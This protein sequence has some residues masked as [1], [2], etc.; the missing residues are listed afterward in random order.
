[1]STTPATDTP[2][3]NTPTTPEID[4]SENDPASST[5]ISD[6]DTKSGKCTSNDINC[7]LTEDYWENMDAEAEGPLVKL[8]ESLP[9]DLRILFQ[10]EKETVLSQ[11]EASGLEWTKVT[12]S[13]FDTTAYVELDN[14]YLE[15]EMIIAAT[16]NPDKITFTEEKYKEIPN[17]SEDEITDKTFVI[18]ENGDMYLPKVT[19]SD[20]M[21]TESVT[22]VLHKLSFLGITFG[23]VLIATFILYKVLKALFGRKPQ[24]PKWHS[25]Q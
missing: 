21:A 13:N 7:Y 22:K 4:Q 11:T 9:T 1:M 23:V 15:S 2:P 25:P 16:T 24:N 14:T 5:D 19:V 8:I 12:D 10:S 17:L 20:K 3:I 18:L 6:Q